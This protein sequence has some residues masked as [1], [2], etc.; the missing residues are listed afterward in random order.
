MSLPQ[1]ER[2]MA[3]WRSAGA[4]GDPEG[5]YARL[6][7]AYGEPH[8]HYHNGQHIAECLSEFDHA[9]HLLR[10]PA[11]VELALWFHDTVYDPKAHDNEER[12]AEM[13]E[14]AVGQAQL[15]RTFIERVTKL[16]MATKPHEA[17]TDSDEAVM[18]DVDLSIL[19]QSAERFAEYEEQ[20]RREYEWVPARVFTSKRAE[21]L[22]KFLGRKQIF[23]TESFREK[24]E[25]SARRNLEASITRL[26]SL[27]R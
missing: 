6:A 16:V 27:S 22:E 2:W 26:K 10:E 14:C 8:R 1:K 12:S 18:V 17:E 3:C 11:A 15:P 23:H 25:R 9:R 19:G 7:S 21:I 20:I 24:Y 13:A 4:A 5:W